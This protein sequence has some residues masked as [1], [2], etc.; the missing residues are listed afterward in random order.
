VR[1]CLMIEGQEGVA[2]ADWVALAQACERLGFDALFRS[3]HYL[4]VGGRHERGSLDAWGTVSALSAITTTLRFGT[5][6]SPATFRHPSVLAKAVVTADHISGGRVELGIGTGWLETEHAAYGFPFPPMGER[7][8]ILAEQLEII[9]RQWGDEPFSFDGAHYRI[10][11]L[12]ARPKPVQRPHP[13]LIVGGAA[14]PRSAALAAKWADE[15][16]TVYVTPEQARERRR[17]LDQACRHEG[18]DPQTLRFS[19]MNGF[20]I[21]ADRN[22]IRARTD[23]LAEW[24]AE[25]GESWIVGTPDDVTARLREYEAAG[26]EAVMLQH[27]LVEDYDAL[28]LIGREVIPALAT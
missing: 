1:I 27:H 13:P 10:E 9:H 2:W 11:D 23:R 16:N 4:S 8:A 24:G 15:Y 6:V 17:A 12:D 22:E 14:G 25:P 3:D 7:M 26:V 19:M 21:G 5:L 20:V 28:E 18:R